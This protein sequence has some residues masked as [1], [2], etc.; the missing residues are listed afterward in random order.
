MFKDQAPE[1]PNP[2]T[3]QPLKDRVR[4]TADKILKNESKFTATRILGS[5][6]IVLSGVILYVD[7]IM[8][9]FNYE[10]VIPEKFL[11][12]GVNFQTFVWLMCQTISPLVLVSGALLRAYSV[13]YLVPIYCYVLQ[14]LFLLKDY[15]LIDDDYLYWYT[16]GM[17][18]LVAFVI[19]VIKYLQVYNIK[20]QIKIAKKKILESNE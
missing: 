20:R 16:F 10:F 19:Q 8:A 7:K 4:A 18:M 5:I 3:Y 12:A 2:L 13:A 14:L 6:A 15:K 11:L 9:L 17:T 1:K